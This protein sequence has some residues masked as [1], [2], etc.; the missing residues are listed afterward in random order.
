M[1][2]KKS[3]A[4]IAILSGPTASGK[5]A[6]AMEWATRRRDIEILSADSVQVYRGADIG[7]A[8]PDLAARSTVP[9]H[10]IDINDPAEVY[11]AGDFVR[12]AEEVISD[13][14]ARGKRI[15]IVG[16]TG[17][18]L[19]ALIY[20][21]WKIPPTSAST[22]SEIR[23]S[24]EG[25]STN[26]LF[27]QLR[28]V[29]SE[30]ASKIMN[31]DRYRMLRG[32]E[33]WLSHHKKPSDLER[34]Q[35]TIADPR[36]ELWVVDR[37]ADELEKRLRQRTQEMLRQGWVEEVRSLRDRWTTSPLWRT[38]GYRQ[39]VDFL[40]GK[41]PEGRN[42]KA[43]NEGLCDEITLAHTQLSKSQRSWFRSERLSQWFVLEAHRKV[44]D[45]AFERVYG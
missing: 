10:L 12:Q 42:P 17:F 3:T 5:S 43:G 28:S 14:T 32:L 31:H 37:P 41:K 20:G 6:I 29:D 9:H 8:K 22:R 33:I 38:A 2:S 27:E 15:L 4:V 35:N 36:F 39:I 30:W 18:Y 13:A 7:S 44:L 24:L 40:D 11:N 23:S 21:M 25:L 1:V 16:G 26:E 45:D 19:K 34:E